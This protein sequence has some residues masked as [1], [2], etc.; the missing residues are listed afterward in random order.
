A[1]HFGRSAEADRAV[2][3]AILAGE[4]AQSRW[5]NREALAHF[6]SALTRLASMP[7]TS[8]NALRRIDAVIKQG[9]IRFALGRHSEQLLLLDSIRRLVEESADPPRLAAWH[10]WT[11]FLHSLTGSRPEVAIGHCPAA[12]R[13]A[14][15]TG[16]P[17][18]SAR[19]ESWP[20]PGYLT[21]GRA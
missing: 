7:D 11:G 21:S 19:A 8:A 4:K 9:E 14:G 10:Y 5:A 16:P 1:Y 12:G 3:Y 6:G 15:S 20:T 17:E 18:L 13:G 2:D